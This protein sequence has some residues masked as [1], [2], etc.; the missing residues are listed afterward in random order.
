M[1][2]H[3]YADEGLDIEEIVPAELA[4]ITLIA[5]PEELRRI[6]QFLE[7]C[8]SRIE[9]CGKSWE[10]EHLSDKD[11]YFTGAPHFVVFNPECDQ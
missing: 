7:N 3:G 2:I 4:E 8:A 10:H 11:R 9:T 5:T 1:K 6:A